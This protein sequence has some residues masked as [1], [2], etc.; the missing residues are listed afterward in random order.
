MKRHL[1]IAGSCMFVLMI[2][3]VWASKVGVGI[4]QPEKE[5]MSIRE[6]SARGGAVRSGHHRTRYFIGGGFRSGK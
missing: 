2:G 5:P 6:E 4:P 3:T 1:I